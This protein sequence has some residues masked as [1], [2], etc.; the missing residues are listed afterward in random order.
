M[1]RNKIW[2][3]NK[4]SDLAC[5]E[6]KR[7]HQSDY[8]ILLTAGKDLVHCRT[9]SCSLQNWKWTLITTWEQSTAYS[10]AQD[11]KFVAWHNAFFL[12]H[13]TT[14]SHT[15]Y[16]WLHKQILSPA[17]LDDE[18][19]NAFVSSEGSRTN[20]VSCLAWRRTRQRLYTICGFKDYTCLVLF[21]TMIHVILCSFRRVKHRACLVLFLTMIQIMS[22]YHQKDREKSCLLLCVITDTKHTPLW[23]KAH[24][25]SCTQ[26]HFDTNNASLRCGSTNLDCCETAP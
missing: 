6:T 26:R 14:C 10:N 24:T 5:W 15:I 22:L 12:W 3:R 23:C 13:V 4:I 9:G 11:V 19:N 21:L 16:A 8:K 18:S 17:F 1:L 2:A 7:W 20:I 25:L